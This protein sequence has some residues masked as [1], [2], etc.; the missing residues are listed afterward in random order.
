[1]S[2]RKPLHIINV[3]IEPWFRKEIIATVLKDLSSYPEELRKELVETIKREVKVSGFR[4]PLTAPKRLLER[5]TE[6]LFEKDAHSISVMIRA[7]MNHYE[8]HATAFDEALKVLKFEISEQAANGYPD[9]GDAFE[10]G[11][12][13]GVDYL[14][15]IEVVR[16]QDDKLDM[17]DDQIVLYSILKT[18]YLP[19]GREE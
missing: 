5:E 2:E 10:S 6:K 3:F 7:W 13:E 11:W 16:Q 9:A 12:P 1:M 14:K 19:G 17:T 18:G 8:K 15:V 4:N